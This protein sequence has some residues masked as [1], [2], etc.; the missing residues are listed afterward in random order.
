MNFDKMK[1]GQKY[2]PDVDVRD[3]YR[4]VSCG[5][6]RSVCPVFEVGGWE[7]T[8]TRG[9]ILIARNLYE[10]AEFE[11]EIFDSINTCTTCGICAKTCPAG[12]NPPALVEGIRK[13]LVDMGKMT[14]TQKRISETV[15]E[16]GNTLKSEE[17]RNSWLTS[18]IQVPKK[19][20]VVYFVGCL[21]SYRYK[22]TALKTYKILNKLGVGLLEDE[23]CCGSPLLRIGFSAE[24][25]TD[26]NRKQFIRS[27]TKTVVVGCAGCYNTLKSNFPEL[28]ILSVSDFLSKNIEKLKSAG[29]KKLDI[30]VS[31]HDPC[32]YGRDNSIFESPRKIILEICTL[33]EMKNT[34][35]K[36]KCCGGGGGV[37]TGYNDLSI[38]IAKRRWE[39][40]PKGVNALVTTCPLCVRNM[41]DSNSNPE[42]QVL[43][44]IDLIESALE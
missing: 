25:Q 7:S 10:G 36:S 2:F 31:F 24:K 32:H 5:N 18:D 3:L 13:G 21:D 8:N 40:L 15:D 4:C 22:E 37:R 19:A 28:E 42:I 14:E 9:R 33:K 41:R 6:C 44:I 26:H 30:T 39:D 34:K 27:G 12:A 23:T 38:E 16:F 29:L 20:D 17:K 43:D 11:E 35:E 1:Y